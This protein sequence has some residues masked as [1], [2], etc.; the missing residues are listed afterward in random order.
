MKVCVF[1]HVRE[2]NRNNC[3]HSEYLINYQSVLFVD[4]M[5]MMLSFDLACRSSMHSL[6]FPPSFACVRLFF[7][8]FISDTIQ[9]FVL[10]DCFSALSFLHSIFNSTFDCQCLH[11]CMLF[12]RLCRSHFAC[13]LNVSV[14]FVLQILYF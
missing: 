5:T 14:A 8:K 7:N 3:L 6:F 9:S 11:L 4:D 1:T 2:P 13:H 12:F 10:S